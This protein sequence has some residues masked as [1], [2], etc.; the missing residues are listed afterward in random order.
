MK[1]GSVHI[2]QWIFEMKIWR[3]EV[4]WRT[5]VSSNCPVERIGY[6]GWHFICVSLIDRNC[7]NK[8]LCSNAPHLIL[9]VECL[10]NLRLTAIVSVNDRHQL[11]GNNAPLCKLSTRECA[12]IIHLVILAHARDWKEFVEGEEN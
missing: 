8:I 9:L 1:Y 5:P 7:I 4:A 6:V 3:L 12:I 10:L 11:T 2:G